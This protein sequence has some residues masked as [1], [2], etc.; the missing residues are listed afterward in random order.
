MFTLVIILINKMYLLRRPPY[1]KA[2]LNILL[3]SLNNDEAQHLS[4]VNILYL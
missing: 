4:I 1:L 3:L 2:T